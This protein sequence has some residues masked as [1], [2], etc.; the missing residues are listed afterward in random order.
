MA[1]EIRTISLW[2]KRRSIK[3]SR[4]GRKVDSEFES[5]IWANLTICYLEE[6]DEVRH[7]TSL[8]CNQFIRL[9]NDAI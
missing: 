7:D 1:L 8:Y 2:N 9:Y 4:R 3:F 6:P 5:E